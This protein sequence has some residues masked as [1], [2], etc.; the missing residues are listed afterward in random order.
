[1]SFEE[2]ILQYVEANHLIEKNTR[3]VLVAVSGGADSVALLYV[4]WRLK[5]QLG[6]QVSA[7]HVEHGIRGEESLADQRF[8]E[9]LCEK[10]SIPLVKKS[11]DAPGY[12][13]RYG[14]SLEE[15]AREL[16]YQAFYEARDAMSEEAVIAVAHHMDDNVETLLLQLVRGTGWRGLGGLRPVYRHVIRPFL[17]VRRSEI[18]SYL[19]ELNQPYCT[20]RTNLDDSIPR[21]RMRH[22][23]LPVLEDLNPKAIDHISETIHGMREVGAFLEDAIGCAFDSVK[24]DLN[25]EEV[26]KLSQSEIPPI[27]RQRFME[28]SSTM[29]KQEVLL[30]WFRKYIP[31]SGHDVGRLHVEK[32]KELLESP[33]NRSWKLPQGWTLD[34]RGKYIYLVPSGESL[35]FPEEEKCL[36][37]EKEELVIGSIQPG[38]HV[39][40]DL[41]DGVL[42]IRCEKKS[43]GHDALIKSPSQGYT[44]CFDYAMIGNNL[45]VRGR[46]TGDFMQVSK[47]GDHKKI[48]DYFID[49][50][51]PREIRDQIPLLVEG[52]RVLWVMGYR[53]STDALVTS[54][55]EN[56]LTISWRK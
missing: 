15:A 38:D 49:Q 44:K 31:F 54:D 30:Y 29:M 46:K 34:A 28:L 35:I 37:K 45:M 51:I 16:R 52:N 9:E 47:A 1:M 6:I 42:D 55:T 17:G 20:D 2:K 12:S 50:K 40:I 43:E 32:G 48:K 5:D 23:I 8:V 19:A 13:K 25:S 26:C 36:L 39:E 14:K 18:E 33:G 22:D 41:M 10:L 56:V 24:G 27:H 53:Q 21:N 3:Q 11:V 7:I 4:L